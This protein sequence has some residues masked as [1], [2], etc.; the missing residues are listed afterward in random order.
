MTTFVLVPGAWHGGWAWDR[1]VPFLERAGART[2]AVDLTLDTDV[3]LAT[4]VAEVVAAIEATG[5]DEVVLV[6]HS[7]AGLVVRQAADSRP[8]RVAHLVV[9]EGWVGA[10][11]ASMLTLAPDW[12]VAGIRAAAGDGPLIPAPPAAMVGI[13]DP[14]D[15]A[16]LGLRLRPHPLRTFTEPTRLTGA[17]DAIPGTAI[18]CLPQVLPFAQLAERVGYPTVTLPGPHDVPLTDPGGLADLLLAAPL[19][20]SD[21]PV[22]R[23]V[24]SGQALTLE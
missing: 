19:S 16:W 3:G 20:T 7:Y 11:G 21:T 17:V 9:V 14:D 5:D 2:V 8:R 23:G 15:A 22:R 24:V 1:V 4:H 10:D 12:F 18:V 13:D 6:G